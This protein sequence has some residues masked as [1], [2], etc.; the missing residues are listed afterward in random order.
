MSNQINTENIYTGGYEAPKTE[1][2]GNSE[3]GKDA[4]LQLLVAQLKYQD[5]LNPS[6]DTEFVAQLATF[7]QLEQLQNLSKTTAN[8]QAFTL[9]GKTVVVKTEDSTGNIKY[10]QGVVDYVNFAGGK[11]KLSINNNLYDLDQLYSVIDDFFLL[12]Q[13]LP[14][15]D[16]KY[17]LS[18]DH[19]EPEDLVFEVNL[20]SG[21]TIADNVAVIIGDKVISSDYVKVVGKNVIIDKEA[22]KYIEAGEHKITMAFNDP[23]YTMVKD[24]I[25]VTIKGEAQVE[26]EEPE[27]GKDESIDG[28]D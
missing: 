23:L 11:A 2:R 7:S 6:S 28:E 4:F 16:K 21:E 24:K 19:K 14:T 22:L 8:S 26:P 27:D 5:P 20:G 1:R 18:F 10:V 17:D 13:G 9:V 15:I 3:L 25:T 12:Q